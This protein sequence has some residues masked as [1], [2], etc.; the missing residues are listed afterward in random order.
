VR[1][2]REELAGWAWVG[3]GGLASVLV[4]L[5]LLL[6]AVVIQLTPD[7]AGFR[8]VIELGVETGDRPP[9]LWT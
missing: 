7:L 5:W 4:P 2:A 1:E 8:D 3:I 9:L 6:T